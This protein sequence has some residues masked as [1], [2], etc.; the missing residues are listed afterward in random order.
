MNEKFRRFLQTRKTAT[1]SL[2]RNRLSARGALSIR[3]TDFGIKPFSAMGGA[4]YV[5]DPIMIEFELSART[6]Q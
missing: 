1:V 2:D 3:Q 5:L 4:L 6:R